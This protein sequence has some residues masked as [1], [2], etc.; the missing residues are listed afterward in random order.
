MAVLALIAVFVSGMP[1]LVRLALSLAALLTALLTLYRHQHPLTR[2]VSYGAGGW[3]LG[4]RDGN[5]RPA[6]LASHVYRGFLLVL[7]FHQE[8][9]TRRQR[10]LLT[11]DNSDA[12]LRRRLVLVL[13][14]TASPSTPA[15]P[16]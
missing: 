6:V 16:D 11:A 14:T 4:D 13:A 5:E 15:G 2:R 9:Q 7:E 12:D 8:S 1:L 10:L 3:L